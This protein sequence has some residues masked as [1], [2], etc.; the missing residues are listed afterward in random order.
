[1][2]DAGT[3]RPGR[4]S[5]PC[6]RTLQA[7]APWLGSRPH[8]SPMSPPESN[9]GA[10]DRRAAGR[11]QERWPGPPFRRFRSP[12]E[13][14]LPAAPTTHA[15]LRA[16]TPIT[17]PRRRAGG[18]A[19]APALSH[20]GCGRTGVAAPGRGRRCGG[21]TPPA[22]VFVSFRRLDRQPRRRRRPCGGPDGK[23]AF[24]A[25]PPSRTAAAASRIGR[26]SGALPPAGDGAGPAIADPD[27]AGGSPGR[28]CRAPDGIAPFRSGAPAATHGGVPISG[29]RMK[30]QA[31]LQQKLA[32]EA[33]PGAPAWPEP[34]LPPPAL[35]RGAGPAQTARA[36]LPLRRG[37][38][39][40]SG[41][42]PCHGGHRDG[43]RTVTMTGRIAMRTL[44]AAR[45]PVRARAGDRTAVSS[46]D[47]GPVG[48]G[49]EVVVSAPPHVGAR[50]GRDSAGGRAQRFPN[51]D[52]VWGHPLCR[53]PRGL[54]CGSPVW[55][56][57]VFQQ[58]SLAS[59]LPTGSTLPHTARY[60]NRSWRLAKRRLRRRQSFARHFARTRGRVCL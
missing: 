4:G 7:P 43:R 39:G 55:Q 60:R 21:G 33:T 37:G 59:R 31:E 6:G 45:L 3:L 36:T 9:A 22:P 20:R 23:A 27:G 58:D 34:P 25:R 10:A 1:M 2:P 5:G 24:A 46:P 28:P 26:P 19:G 49:L 29:N 52:G 30:S 51:P 40:R 16:I 57:T 56:R 15:P 44:T 50:Q 14:N 54:S 32:A 18:R 12:P 47:R 17:A 42:P 53:A 13:S 35:R 8:Q 38:A 48:Q 41:T 11:V